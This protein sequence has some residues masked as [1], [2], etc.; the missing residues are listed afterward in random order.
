MVPHAFTWLHALPL[1]PNGKIDRQALP[2]FAAL[3]A[4]APVATVA[5]VAAMAASASPPAAAPAAR[6]LTLRSDAEQV[7]RDIWLRVLGV[8][9]IGVHD[10]FFEL[11]GH[12]ILAVK[13]QSELSRAFGIRLPI[14]E[15]FR[16]PTIEALA[17]HFAQNPVTPVTTASQ[18]TDK[19]SR[20]TAAMNRR[21]AVIGGR[22]HD[23]R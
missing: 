9:E 20:R 11:G 19:A 3:A 8:A 10:N 5:T 21:V 22:S 23:D 13:V 12:S 15:L 17:A 1:T 2:S 6:V 18:A 16:S 14:V 4:V 7:I